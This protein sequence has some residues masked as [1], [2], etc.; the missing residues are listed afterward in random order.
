LLEKKTYQVFKMW[1]PLP[2]P[3]RRAVD[4]V[5]GRAAEGAFQSLVRRKN[6]VWGRPKKG[7]G[8]LAYE[9]GLL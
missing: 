9:E 4:I 7:A 2:A 8:P 3:G 5:E 6:P 1:S